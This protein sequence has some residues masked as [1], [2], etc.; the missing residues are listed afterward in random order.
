MR[1][2]LDNFPRFGNSRSNKMVLEIFI[3]PGHMSHFYFRDVLPL[4]RRF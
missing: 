3:S 1:V 2:P 4:D